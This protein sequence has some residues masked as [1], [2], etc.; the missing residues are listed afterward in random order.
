MS[1]L[2]VKPI[3]GCNMGCIG[4]YEGEIFRQNGN[5]PLPYDLERIKARILK[6]GAKQVVLHGGEITL[7]PVADLENLCEAI[8]ADDREIHMQTNGSL[9]TPTM[10]DFI[11][12]YSIYVGVSINGPAELNRDRRA[13]PHTSKIPEE[14]M[15]KATD[16][17]TERIQ[18]NIFKM[19]DGGVKVGLITVLSQTNAGTTDKLKKLINWGLDF[20]GRGIHSHRWNLLHQDF[21][22]PKIELTPDEALLA[23]EWLAGT[24]FENA[25]RAWFPFRSMFRSLNG[26]SAEDCWFAPCDPYATAA[27][28]AVFH[29]GS[30]GNCLR[31]AKDGI[32]YLRAEDGEQ[33]HRQEL[34]ESIPFEQGGCGGCKYWTICYG[35]CPAEAVDSDWRNKSRFC[36]V[37]YGTYDFLTA[38]RRA[39]DPDWNPSIGGKPAGKDLFTASMAQ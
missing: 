25:T 6:D 38:R 20:E 32:P 39:F 9:I 24:T 28:R 34:L 17:M 16:K 7:M 14:I 27:V 12:R 21:D 35:G 15:L 22:V 13:V 18:N 36:K 1:S 5:K 11:Q 23:Y 19:L 8:K 3:L 33:H 4:C 31:T 10:L 29:D 26:Y 37:F 2:T 30:M